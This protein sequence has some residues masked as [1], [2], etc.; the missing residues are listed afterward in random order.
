M[1]AHPDERSGTSRAL[2]AGHC[3]GHLVAVAG[4][5]ASGAQGL[6]PR[7]RWLAGV[8]TAEDAGSRGGNTGHETTTHATLALGERFRPGLA[9][10][11]VG[12]VESCALAART[13]VSRALA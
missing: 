10:D 5:R 12:L 7:G 1:A 13:V 9:G 4:G 2:V 3:R 8:G 11:P 6:A